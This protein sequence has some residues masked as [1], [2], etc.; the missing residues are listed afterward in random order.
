MAFA[1]RVVLESF[2]AA[3][4][5]GAVMMWFYNRYL[6]ALRESLVK[7]A[8]ALGTLPLAAAVGLGHG[9]AL[10]LDWPH[11]SALAWLGLPVT[12]LSCWN[13]SIERRNNR[14]A[15]MV[16]ESP[17]D[18]LNYRRFS[19]PVA[20]GLRATRMLNDATRLQLVRHEFPVR[21]LHPSLHGYRILFLTDFH[22]HPTL[23]EAYFRKTVDVALARN[24]DVIL[25]GGDFISKPPWR[26]SAQRLL[27]RLQ[28]HPRVIAVRGNH[29]FWTWPAFF[30]GMLREWNVELLSNDVT[31]LERDGG[32]IAVVGLEDPYVPLTPRRE[33]EL[34]QRLQEL[35][36]AH[37]PL[38]RIGLVHTPETYRAAERLD[39][40]LS[41]AG[42]THGGQIRLPLFGTTIAACGVRRQYAYGVGHMNG[43]T[44]LTSNGLG[45]FFPIRFLCPPQILEVELTNG[46]RG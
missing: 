25:L 34:R 6:S 22:V 10:L 4:F 15:R 39:C 8:M 14:G 17:K 23:T 16:S 43:M 38:P 7:K 30:S 42:H 29:D 19:G 31:V 36:E 2:F 41:F 27:A 45:V 33:A 12:L 28:E 5:A 3:V 40:V 35:D 32:R 9:I 26:K 13:L 37:G 18:E 11:I 44:T 21:G 46:R 20:A 24:P 1:L